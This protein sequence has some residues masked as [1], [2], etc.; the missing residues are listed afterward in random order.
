M[1]KGNAQSNRRTIFPTWNY[2]EGDTVRVSGFTNLS[3]AELFLNGKSLGRKSLADTKENT[4]TWDVI[5]QPGELLVK[6]YKDGA[7]SNTH[8]LKTAGEA[9]AI[10]AVADRKSF[11]K[12]QKQLAH[13]EISIV[14][15]LGIP[16]F[17]ADNE[18]TVGIEGSAQLLGLES[19]SS[20]SHEDYKSNKRKAFHGKLL[21]YIQSQKNPGTC[22]LRISSPGL[23]EQ[24]IELPNL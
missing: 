14:D 10:K 17:L 22:K 9:Y 20:V 24:V 15:K 4:I 13:I 19:G 8:T 11:N 3:E 2:K 5:Y 16:V 1:P 18:I 7:S 21:A 12:S 6:G 23:K